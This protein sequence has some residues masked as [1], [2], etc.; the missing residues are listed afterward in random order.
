[1]KRHDIV[2][3]VPE[4]LYYV[5]FL[6]MLKK[7]YRS[8]ADNALIEPVMEVPHDFLHLDFFILNLR[9]PDDFFLDRSVKVFQG[10]FTMF[11]HR[12]WGNPIKKVTRALIR[13]EQGP[14]NWVAQRRPVQGTSSS[15][16]C[17]GDWVCVLYHY[18]AV[19]ES[20]LRHASH[21]LLKFLA[22]KKSSSTPQ[23]R[24]EFTVIVMPL[25]K[26]SKYQ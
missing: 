19:T 13:R 3:K 14:L 12:S 25:P 1:M 23:Y 10:A 4:R 6:A 20:S 24:S 8:L 2:K 21:R 26:K 9:Y 5:V 11:R 22:S 16:W 15:K 17:E 18:L 7:L